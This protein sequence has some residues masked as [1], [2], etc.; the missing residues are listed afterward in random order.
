MGLKGKT[1]S[2]KTESLDRVVTQ[3]SAAKGKI[4]KA[5]LKKMDKATDIVFRVATQKRPM[6]SHNQMKAEGRSKRVSDP[7]A[8]AGVPVQTGA[9]RA[10]IKKKVTQ[11]LFKTVGRIW[12][13]MSYAKYVEFGT[14]KMAARPFLRPAINLTQEA[15]KSLFAKRE[16]QKNA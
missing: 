13:D 7:S 14:S 8:Q 16:E 1:F 15:I 2:I 11:S 6:I 4:D 5:V 12:T 9:L 10:S 3:I